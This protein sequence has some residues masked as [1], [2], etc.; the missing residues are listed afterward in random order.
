MNIKYWSSYTSWKL[1]AVDLMQRLNLVFC[2]SRND[3]PLERASSQFTICK[4]EGYLELNV[5]HL[6]DTSKLWIRKSKLM[7]II[8]VSWSQQ[9]FLKKKMV[10][11]FLNVTV[12]LGLFIFCFYCWS[13][14]GEICLIRITHEW[15]Y[16]ALWCIVYLNLK[17]LLQGSISAIQ[18]SWGPLWFS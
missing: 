14:Y 1:N 6:C 15:D 9:V 13:R 16:F 4:N 10:F 2:T 17:V 3:W 12:Y 11:R 18:V 8:L 5:G 7:P